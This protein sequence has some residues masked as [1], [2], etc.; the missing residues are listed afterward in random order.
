MKPKVTCKKWSEDVF[1]KERNKVLSMW[2]TGREVDLDEAIEYHKRLPQHKR[3]H[4][5]AEDLTRR[6]KTV[7]FPR[8]GTPILEDE[9]EL[10]RSLVEAGL[11]LLPVTPDSYCRRGAFALAEK[12][13]E[14]SIKTG[15]PKLNGYPTVIHGVK[16]T[17][18]VIESADAAFNQRL[19]NVGGVRLMA[20]IAFASGMTAALVDPILTFACYE[21]NFSAS[22]CIEHYQYIWR[23]V[24]LYAELGVVLCVDFDGPEPTNLQFP[25]GVRIASIVITS[26]LAAEQGVKCIMP[27]VGIYGNLIQDVAWTNVERRLVRE[28]LD[29]F[30]YGDVQIPGIFLD[31]TPLFPYPQDMPWCFAFLNY[32]AV[33]AAIAGA[34]AVYVRTIDEGV[35]LPTKDAHAMSYR[36]ANWI[37]EVVRPQKISLGE[38][39][40]LEEKMTELETRALIEKCLELGD[41]DP[42]VGYE[43][44]I[45][46]GM[47]DF[48]LPMNRH[49][50]GKVLGIRDVKGAC[51]YLEFGNLPLPTEVKQFHR[52]KVLEREKREGRKMDYLVAIEDF[53]AFS[54]GRIKSEP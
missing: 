52:E 28:Y 4:A 1:Y 14:E 39:L 25:A 7:I 42:A 21:K 35:G 30:G 16:N 5:V 41:G 46:T 49:C 27:R 24:G 36:S 31:Q 26:L 51:R 53:W 2:P 20:E 47:I 34:T 3:F 50:Q 38:E 13:L 32:S 23:L 19:T 10:N 17:R 40:E 33:T 22:E 29:R 48:P 6:Q 43:R 12:G 15:K 37:F 54:K 18:K 11:P 45:E 9:I 44:A 8:A